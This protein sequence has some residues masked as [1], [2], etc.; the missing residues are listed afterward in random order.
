[1]ERR[2]VI[3]GMGVLIFIGNDV[4]IFWNNVKEGKLG[5]DFIILID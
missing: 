2:V 4:N 5:I 1:M 3:I